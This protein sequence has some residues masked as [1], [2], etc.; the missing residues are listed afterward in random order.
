LFEPQ[1]T[2]YCAWSMPAHMSAAPASFKDEY[3]ISPFIIDLVGFEIIAFLRLTNDYTRHS[4]FMRG[5][6]NLLLF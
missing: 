6:A 5:A 3:M 1:V 2:R 4:S